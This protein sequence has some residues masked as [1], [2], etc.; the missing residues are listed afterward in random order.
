MQG[1]NIYFSVKF[2][3]GFEQLLFNS[4]FYYGSSDNLNTKDQLLVKK[5]LQN[6][7]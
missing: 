4:G 6:K 7:T 3:L 1:K 5:N 2:L